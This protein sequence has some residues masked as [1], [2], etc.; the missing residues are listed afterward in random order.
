[1]TAALRRVLKD[2]DSVPQGRYNDTLTGKARCLEHEVTKVNE[3][4]E[5]R[6]L[7]ALGFLAFRGFMLHVLR[8]FS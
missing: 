2:T 7:H 5:A 4:R 8:S 6:R 1:M 3:G